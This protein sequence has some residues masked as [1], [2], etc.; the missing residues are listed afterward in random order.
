MAQFVTANQ[1]SPR[2]SFTYKPFDNTTFHAGYARYFTPP[3][4]VEAVPANIAAFNNTTGAP[5]AGQPADP[6]LPE[7]SHYFDAGVVQKFSLGCSGPS[8]RDCATLELGVDGY[9]KTAKDLLDDGTFGQAL[10]LSAFNYAKGIN[11]GVEFSAKYANGNFQAYGNLAVA[12]Q[13]ATNVVSNQYLFDNT[14]PLADLGGL[15]E[16]Q[17][18]ATHWVYTDHNQ[19]VT[20]SAGLSYL[21]NGTRFSTDMIYGSGLRTGDANIGSEAPYAQFNAGISHEFAQ[22]DGKPITVRFDAVNL[23]DTIYQIRSGTGIG[24]FAPQFGPRRGYYA[25]I[26]KKF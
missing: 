5:P 18:I 6:V 15:T 12:Q 2:L 1:L 13:K 16:F 23:F 19:F 4:L 17:Y 25:G 14:T 7:R 11:E 9:Y 21:W 24:V 3:V 10:V 22:P 8:S 20:G 26:T